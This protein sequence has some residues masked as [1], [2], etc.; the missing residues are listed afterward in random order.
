MK[1]NKYILVIT[2]ATV[3]LSSCK[4]SFL[5]ETP[6]TAVPVNLAIVTPNDMADAVNG[7]Y[8]AAKSSSLFGRDI[9][10]LGDELADNIYV[11]I[12]NSGR[13]LVENN[14]SYVNTTAEPADIYSQGY[15]TILQANRIIAAPVAASNDVN[16]L[17][18]EAYIMR[19]LTNL[20]MVNFFGPAFTVSSTAPGISV[21]TVPS[22][23]SGPFVKPARASVA[24]AYTQIISDLD[25][26]YL[27]MPTTGTTLHATNSEFLSKYAA[28]AIEARA[29]LYKGDYTNATAAALLVVQN[30]GY[31]LSTTA[32]AFTAYWASPA[33]VTN[34]TETIF[35]LANTATSN[36]G[37][38]GLD[39]MYWQTGAYGD[40]L[41]TDDLY[42][43]YT[44]TDWRRTLII[45]GTRA[46]NQ[47]YI[48]NKYPNYANSAD[49]DDLKII[50]YAE[51]LL[52]LAEGYAQNGDNIN[53]LKYLNQVATNRDPSFLGYT[54]TGAALIAD[55]LNERRKEL[56]FEGLRWFDLKRLN[57][58]INRPQEGA[59]KSYPSYPTVS[60]TDFRRLLPI[61]LGEINANP[62]IV[63]NPSY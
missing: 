63:Q 16:Q 27:I 53:G 7:M 43:Q 13:Y 31:T 52:T 32:T 6:P 9:P 23:I 37:T 10:I 3:A 2:A 29:Y 38:N 47:A 60:T 51:V 36:N 30:G 48:N 58:V 12:S 59:T 28:K 21:V 44:A 11:S 24:S 55:I 39:A 33:P 35:E 8:V 34:K 20:M 4:K 18:G 42:N 56:A 61:P 26:A 62:A 57:L 40:M 50:R 54:D 49:K 14:Y 45:N 22:S 5:T 25:S 17:K 1:I 15:Y 41:A 46:G 19:A